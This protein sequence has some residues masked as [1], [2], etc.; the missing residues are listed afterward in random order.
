MLPSQLGACLSAYRSG[1]LVQFY[2]DTLE[3]NYE[4]YRQQLQKEKGVNVCASNASTAI[5]PSSPQVTSRNTPRNA[6]NPS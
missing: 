2:T 1:H 3:Q 5:L 4:L 6:H